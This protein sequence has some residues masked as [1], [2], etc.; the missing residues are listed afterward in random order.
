M[1]GL[2]TQVGSYIE[3]MVYSKLGLLKG[4]GTSRFYL[5]WLHFAIM[6]G[7]EQDKV[8]LYKAKEKKFLCIIIGLSWYSWYCNSFPLSIVS[9]AATIITATAATRILYSGII[10]ETQSVCH[11][12]WSD[13][14]W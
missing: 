11:V 5:S 13:A 7:S 12:R 10:N 1:L 2:S 4:S 6:W 14:M 8:V 3:A 9:A